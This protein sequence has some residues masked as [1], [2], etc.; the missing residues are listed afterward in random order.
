RA[1][2]R[3]VVSIAERLACRADLGAA[4]GDIGD[5]VLPRDDGIRVRHDVHPLESRRAEHGS[6]P[7]R[8]IARSPGSLLTSSRS[9]S[10]R[11]HVG[12]SSD[13]NRACSSFTELTY[14]PAIAPITKNGSV[15]ATTAGGR[16]VSGDS[17]D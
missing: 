7:S 2:A 10:S 1:P 12:A 13:Q 3:V 5:P 9:P 17:W 11:T 8:S 4:P 15:P 14:P 6:H 16:G